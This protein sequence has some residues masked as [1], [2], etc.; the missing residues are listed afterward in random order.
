MI[1]VPRRTS[2]PHLLT[3]SHLI[4]SDAQPAQQALCK[5]RTE[6]VE[7][8]RAMLDRSNANFLLWPPCVEVQRCSGC[9]NAKS[10]QCVPFVTHTRYLQVRDHTQK[11]G[12]MSKHL[13]LWDR[14][15]VLRLCYCLLTP[16][17]LSTSPG[18]ED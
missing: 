2:C 18:H 1:F 7:V 12:Q 10:L 9:C 15:R 3:V 11:H 4:P 16:M 5:V 6:V 17:F 14:R 13:R 8:T